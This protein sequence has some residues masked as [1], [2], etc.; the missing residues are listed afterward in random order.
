MT[1]IKQGFALPMVVVTGLVM[2]IVM[3]YALQTAFITRDGLIANRAQILSRQAAESGLARAR[4]CVAKNDNTI[5]WTK[6]KPLRPN[7]DCKGEIIFT[8]GYRQYVTVDEKYRTTFEVYPSEEGDDYLAN[9]SFGKVE[10]L[11]GDSSK[12]VIRQYSHVSSAYIKT[13]VTF[14]DIQFG[15]IY[16]N[17]QTGQKFEAVYFLT[18]TI[19][20]HIKGVGRNVNSILSGRAGYGNYY[21]NGVDLDMSIDSSL[22]FKKIITD[23]QGNGWNVY[24]QTYNNEVYTTGANSH[25]V[26]G[27]AN[28]LNGVNIITTPSLRDPIWPTG[29]KMALPSGVKIKKVMINAT[30]GYVIT[31]DGRI[32]V[33]GFNY[34]PGAGGVL[35]CY[36]DCN[37]NNWTLMN[38]PKRVQTSSGTYL[39]N[40][41]TVHVD[42]FYDGDDVVGCAIANTNISD[43]T[44]RNAYC[45]GNN[46]RRQI[47]SYSYLNNSDYN[48]AYT[49]PYA[50]PVYTNQSDK[51]IDVKTDG[52][53]TYVL[54]EKG[55][56]FA[57]GS[58]NHYQL[59]SDCINECDNYGL[60]YS[61]NAR[62]NCNSRCG[63]RQ[64]A[65]GGKKITKMMVDAF[66]A[67][68][69][70]EDG[71][72][73]GTGL[74]DMGQLGNGSYD[75]GKPYA[76]KMILPAGV[77]VKDI[78]IVSPGLYR[79]GFQPASNSYNFEREKYNA[80]LY[81]NAFVISENGNV[82][83]VGSNAFGQ[84]GVGNNA[85]R[86]QILAMCPEMNSLEYQEARDKAS[87]HQDVLDGPDINKNN[88]GGTHNST[89]Y[90]RTAVAK[91]VKM[92][93]KTKTESGWKEYQSKIDGVRAGMG[94]AIV[95][96]KNNKVFTVGHNH[97]GQLGA[98]DEKTRTIPEAHRLTNLWR[99][100]YY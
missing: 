28:P 54:T 40:V 31:D 74:N 42:T 61:S 13:D 100:Y 56:V 77:K 71:V 72:V 30:S 52:F 14:D 41:Q 75:E 50:Y 79:Q 57:S 33:V 70:D 98:G 22:K 78:F 93:L 26:V 55:R 96:T 84:L 90:Y 94:T 46:E 35:G 97:H 83:G 53:T 37:G 99:V 24:F 66:S 4:Q 23:F 67:L 45:W 15:S 68:F 36:R 39:E 85:T 25:G 47:M 2:L 6:D 87:L 88:Y 9:S 17:S 29:K 91:P 44:T 51:P 8:E 38:T 80:R 76:R 7:T 69:L 60:Y 59:G 20:G 58:N 89:T 19:S 32:Y 62:F 64:I 82:Y 18:K 12:R 73:W 16:N 11:A 92:C 81:R 86:H 5:S 43:K 63:Q 1:N 27:N 34:F 10:L 21:A 48:K 49:V 65:F 3:T 95:I